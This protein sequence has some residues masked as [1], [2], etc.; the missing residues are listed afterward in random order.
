MLDNL[1]T[2]VLNAN[3]MPLAIVPW[4]RGL[5]LA[6]DGRAAELDFYAGV[7]VRDGHGRHYTVPAV[8][9]LRHMK[10]V[11]H[12]VA[13]FC[14]KNVY[15]RDALTCQYCGQR[16]EPSGLTIDH[17]VPRSRWA[18]KGTPTTWENVVT[19]CVA[20]NTR[21]ANKTCDQAGMHP[22]VAPTRPR[23]GEMFLGLSPWRDRVPA[24]WLPYLR[25]L[26]IFRGID[27]HV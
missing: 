19:C 20:C 13:P 2:L 4:G 22:M 3:G 27:E 8:V 23:Y 6:Y 21:K 1:T 5:C 25:H 17:V 9:I 26:P 18:G 12:R 7:K 16:H 11:D 15:L 10:K 14:K 24:E